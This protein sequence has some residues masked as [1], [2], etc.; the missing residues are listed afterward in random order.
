MKQQAHGYRAFSLPELL[1]A[2]FIV[3]VIMQGFTTLF[4]RS[5]ETNKTILR[6]GLASSLAQQASNR[7]IVDLRGVQQSASGS[8]P[9]AEANSFSLTV[10]LDT[11]N[12]GAVER[13]HYYLDDASNELRQGITE[14]NAGTLPVTYP[15]GDTTTKVLAKYVV[16]TTSEP[17][18]YYYNSNYPGDTVNNPLSTPASTGAIQLIR[19]R[20]L[21]NIDPTHSTRSISM[22]SFVDLRNLN[23]YDSL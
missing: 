1:V 16:N 20:L 12:D 6:T 2:L 13:V 10:Y 14:P 18:F 7:V 21:V 8:F 11:N 17:I 19:V 4:L 9:V 3:A 23:N 15:T 22:E 5:W